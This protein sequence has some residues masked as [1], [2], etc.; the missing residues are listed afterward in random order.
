[1]SLFSHFPEQTPVLYKPY[2]SAKQEMQGIVLKNCGGGVCAIMVYNFDDAG[3][4]VEVYDNCYHVHDPRVAKFSPEFWQDNAG[5][6]RLAPIAEAMD[7][8]IADLQSAVHHHD[9]D[10][11]LEALTGNPERRRR[12]RPTNAEIEA[13]RLSERAAAP[14]VEDDCE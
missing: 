8:I 6:F 10:G 13:R 2:P 3:L 14:V 12:G 7:S 5:I 4:R 11:E 9:D 1:M